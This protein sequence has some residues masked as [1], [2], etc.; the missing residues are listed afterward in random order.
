MACLVQGGETTLRLG[1]APGRGGR[2]QHL[3][4]AAARALDIAGAGDAITLLAA[5]TDGRDGPT[6]AAGATVAVR[7]STGKP[8]SQSTKLCASPAKSRA[9]STMRTGM[10]SFIAT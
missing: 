8:S 3:A 5:G 7:D 1:D 2:C 4:L 6:D 10:E 9:P